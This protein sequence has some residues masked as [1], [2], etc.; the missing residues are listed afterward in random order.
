MWNTVVF[1][2]IWS[3]VGIITTNCQFSL[4]W[5]EGVRIQLRFTV[6]LRSRSRFTFAP[7]GVERSARS[8]PRSKWSN[9]SRW[10]NKG[11]ASPPATSR[12]LVSD[13]H[14]VIPGFGAS[15]HRPAHR[16]ASLPLRAGPIASFKVF[17]NGATVAAEFPS[18]PTPQQVRTRR[19][20]QPL[21]PHLTRKAPP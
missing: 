12:P 3:G 17:D 14:V 20:G 11:S 4:A 7:R 21:N 8:L 16:I 19:D 13:R 10:P 1:Q 5:P 15:A 18:P 9:R 6:T 2:C